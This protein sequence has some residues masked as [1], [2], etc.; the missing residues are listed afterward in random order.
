MQASSD[1]K[2][3][4]KGFEGF[5]KS[6]PED[7]VEYCIF[8]VDNTTEG[9]ELRDRLRKI[10]SA[11]T[12]LTKE[13]T[14]DF[15]WQKEGFGLDLVNENDL[16]FLRGRTT[17][18]DAIDDEWLVVYLLRELSRQFRQCWIRL[19][20]SDGQF[21]L[22]E[23]ANVLP[24]W[25]NPDNADY[26]IWL[27]DGKLFIIP[28]QVQTESAPDLERLTLKSAL[29]IIKEKNVQLVHSP[30]VEN[31]SFFRLQKYPS[32]IKGSLHRALVLI[33]RRLAYILHKNPRYI[34]AAVESF[35]LRDP[36]SLRPLQTLDGSSLWFP[37]E[38]MVV[39][40]VTFT[41]VGYAQLKSQ[42]FTAPRLWT[43]QPE[44]A[45][46]EK[47]QPQ[48]N[49]GMKVTCGFEML[50]S[51]PQNVDKK[52]IREINLLLQDLKSGEDSLPTDSEIS[53]W[54]KIEDDDGWLDIN[55][56]EFEKELAGK[57]HQDMAYKKNG[58][59]DPNAQDQL[60]RMVG[61]FE[62]FLSDEMAGPE[63]ADDMGD[64]SSD[65]AESSGSETRSENHD[66]E[67]ELD[68]NQFMSMVRDMMG[69]SA[70]E[71][72]R[73]AQMSQLGDGGR[74]NATLRPY[75]K[76]AGKEEQQILQV[77]EDVESEL[78]EAGMLQ[79][80]DTMTDP[81]RRISKIAKEL[82]P[83]QPSTGSAR[84]NKATE[85]ASDD[86]DTDEVNINHHLAQNL[87][88]SFSSQGGL[89]GPGGNLMGM[90][91]IHMPRNESP[92][93]DTSKE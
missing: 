77:M 17:Y 31:E 44:I 16:S 82:A 34:T 87:L 35:Y 55:F 85:A 70:S 61:K 42:E 93:E 37:P 76:A 26:R 43:A 84:S 81:A 73:A 75:G 30:Q 79:I 92:A 25:L 46:R 38:D 13:L 27:N 1:F 19:C 12:K 39:V 14:K 50:L 6:L 60:R 22:I 54:D 59:G 69:D 72:S 56:E 36:V 20:D 2:W 7:C 91:G 15:I 33:P 63:G 8:H 40:S 23:A 24:P 10:Q 3:F 41:K 45:L 49:L 9:L 11:A 48:I 67:I 88:E 28:A 64:E 86:S 51:D 58:F 65:S 74:S 90:L 29:R 4:G 5:P 68:Q 52:S 78:K 71:P 57:R 18:G 62:A 53:K 32:Q 80:D 21:L 47:R 89:A 83:G 66:Q